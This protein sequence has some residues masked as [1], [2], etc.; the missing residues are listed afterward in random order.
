VSQP[1]LFASPVPPPID[2]VDLRCCDVQALLG[3]VRGAA[4][5]HADPP[6]RY[7]S[8][9]VPRG[10]A[11][12]AEHYSA[13]A[14]GDHYDGLSD[15]DIARHVDA[16]FGC[17]AHN[18]YLVLWTTWPKLY[19]WVEEFAR[20]GKR[21][22]YVTGGAWGKT[23]SGAGIGYHW[24]GNSEPVLIYKKGKPKPCAT[25][26]NFCGHP[27]GE[28]SEKPLPMLEDMARAFCPPGGLVFD[29]YA[30][31]GPMARACLSESRRYIG[32]EIDEER[33]RKALGLLALAAGRSS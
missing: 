30:G 15:F 4:M 9:G 24:R 17:A 32:A 6:W 29:L 25:I 19:E 13:G 7:R 22:K 5:I 3:E 27:R 16:A 14:V 1:V 21:W 12:L 8:A 31:L 18:A 11:A 28:H 33:H 20:H 26:S 10:T 23:D 2:G